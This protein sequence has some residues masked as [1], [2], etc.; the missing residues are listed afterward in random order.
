MTERETTR[1]V[2]WS[3][4][5]RRVHH[6]LREALDVTRTALDE[7]IPGES[8]TRELLLYCHGFCA[9]LDSHHQGEDRTLFPAIAAAHPEL[10]PVLRSLEQDHS[11]IA[12]LLGGL[13]AAVDRAASPE[14]LDRHLEGIA[15]LM[16]NHFR[17]EE[18]QLLAVLE[19]L[20]LS[21]APG[22]VLG[23]L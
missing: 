7:G 6:R 5:L 20:E 15:A 2:A 22:E 10:R 18:R 16:E 12:H 17:Y 21:A 1:L 11:M 19:T 4:E 9:A 14:E 13:R 3:Q 23:P 8:A